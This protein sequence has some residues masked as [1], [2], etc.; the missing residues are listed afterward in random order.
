MMRD[1]FGR[2][3]GPGSPW[4]LRRAPVRPVPAPPPAAAVRAPREP[5][6]APPEPPRYA[7]R[8]PFGP[9]PSRTPAALPLEEEEEEELLARSPVEAAREAPA[10]STPPAP[11]AATAAVQL[12]EA[13]A[14]MEA[15][16][17]RLARE[18]DREREADKLRLVGEVLPALDDLDRSIA[19]AHQD[20]GVKPALL[21]G[22]ELVRTRLER[23]LHG[24]GLER[25]EAIGARFDPALHEAIALVQVDD[26]RSVGVVVDEI[27]RGYRSGERVVRAARVRVGVAG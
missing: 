10:R 1:V 7:T 2:P 20:G 25:I 17:A 19:A 12:A 26:P 15:S 18:A 6:R 24:Y 13:Q 3:I 8:P 4:N 16:R 14:E 11:P 23:V 21:E 22:F 27:E 5:L 9:P